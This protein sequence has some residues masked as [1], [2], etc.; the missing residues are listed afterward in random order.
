MFEADVFC[1]VAVH[2]GR[3]VG[4]LTRTDILTPLAALAEEE[5]RAI[6]GK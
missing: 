5:R 3:P 6:R 2:D 4:I 1:L